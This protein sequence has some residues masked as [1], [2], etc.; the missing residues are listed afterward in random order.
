[1]IKQLYLT[2]LIGFM[3]ISQFSKSQ[4][5]NGSIIA[6]L[7]R[8]VDNQEINVD[9]IRVNF[10]P[11]Y[12]NEVTWEDADKMWNPDESLAVFNQ[13][14]YLS[15]D[16]RNVYTTETEVQFYVYNYVAT[17]YRLDIALDNIT[18]A[19]IYDSFADS[20]TTLNNGSNTIY[21]S[22]QNNT[23]SAAAERFKI[24]FL[25]PFDNSLETNTSTK[26]DFKIYPNP[27]RDG[28]FKLETYSLSGTAMKIAV[29]DQLGRIIHTETKTPTS[30]DLS[31][32][33]STKIKTGTYVVQIKTSSQ[34]LSQR[35]I[36]L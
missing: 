26:A 29:F 33:L 1:M 9:G 32:N 5:N 15:I 6:D 8:V 4:T 23:G 20:Y 10:E 13:G 2:T 19:Y 14:Y 31:L 21:Y 27:S 22:V 3:L 34:Q 16:K 30:N 25:N 24:L 28:Q 18:E 12:S 36:V 7:Y 17:N 35:L 11:Q